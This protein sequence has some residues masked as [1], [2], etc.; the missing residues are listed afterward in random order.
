MIWLIILLVSVAACVLGLIYLTSRITGLFLI[1]RNMKPRK[2][3]WLS[4][5]VLMLLLIALGV[6]WGIWNSMICFLHLLLFW[7]LCDGVAV[8]LGLLRRK[9]TS[10]D[11]EERKTFVAS[12]RPYYVGVTAIVITVVYLGAGFYY[13][14]HVAR[15]AY[16]FSTTKEVETIKIVGFSDSHVG[17]TFHWQGFEKYVDEMNAEKPDMV[18]IVGD[19]VDDDTSKEDMEKCCE[20]LSGLETTY[21]V[22]FVFGNHDRG[23]YGEEHR[24]YGEKELVENLEKNGVIVLCDEILPITEHFYLCGRDDSQRQERTSIENMMK[25]VTGDD[26]VLVLDHEPNDYI[27]EA[28]AGC[29]LVLSG[30]THG[31]QMIPIIKVGEWL[32]INDATYGYERRE[33]TDFV[34][35]S[36]ISDWAIKFKTGCISEY[37]VIEISK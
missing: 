30:H 36:G 11:E 27:L 18:V 3:K 2:A 26:Y 28:E 24:G 7:L 25:Q 10:K 16:E 15:T 21:G 9:K 32:G 22:Y 31:G 20:A 1:N 37:F 8:I 4:F 5:G 12:K 19:F 13:A 23:Y 33:A 6:L 14:H 29:D 35:S 34:V 17:T